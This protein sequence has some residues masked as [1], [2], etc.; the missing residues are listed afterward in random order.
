[1]LKKIYIEHFE[2]KADMKKVRELNFKNLPKLD[3]REV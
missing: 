3:S 1:M 2:E